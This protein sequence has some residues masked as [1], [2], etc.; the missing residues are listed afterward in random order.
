MR[1]GSGQHRHLLKAALLLGAFV[2]GMSAQRYAQWPYG[3]LNETVLAYQAGATKRAAIQT[4]LKQPSLEQTDHILNIPAAVTHARE[5]KMQPGL[6]LLSMGMN[7][8]MLV[9]SQGRVRHH[10]F[11]PFSRIWDNPPHIPD[12]VPDVMTFILECEAYPNGDLLAIY[13]TNHDTPYGYAMVKMDRDSR[14]L[15]SLPLNA[16]HSLHIADNGMLYTLTQRYEPNTAP[17]LAHLKPPLLHDAVRI[18]SPD[19]EVLDTIPVLEAFLDTPYEQMLFYKFYKEAQKSNDYSHA[20]S[21]MPLEDRLAAKFPMFRPGQILVSIRNLDAI[22]VIDPATRKVVWAMQGVW[23]YQHEARFTEDGHIILLDN[24]GFQDGSRHKRS[25]VLM[26]DPATGA[27]PWTFTGAP[28][29]AFFTSYRGMAQVLANG[30]VLTVETYPG[31]RL[32]E[33]TPAREIVWKYEVTHDPGNNQTHVIYMAHRY[34][35]GYFDEAFMNA[36]TSRPAGRP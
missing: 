36:M 23:R 28:E 20:N 27:I 7:A 35:P 1:R 32:L 34:A 13:Q 4:A 24:T 15:W 33:V 29:D 26:L 8:A 6:T 3:I 5:E 17:G 25:R 2:Y 18:L 10:W 14:I 11:L 9:D 12:P 16:H 30:N 22:A 19:G 21:V 31:R